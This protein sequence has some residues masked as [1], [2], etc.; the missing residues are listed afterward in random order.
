MQASTR[1][2]DLPQRAG[3]KVMAGAVWAA[4][5][6]CSFPAQARITEINVQ[7]IE[8]FAGGAVFGKTGA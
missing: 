2:F 3:M 4:A 1:L 5:C 7:Q 6:L 8:P